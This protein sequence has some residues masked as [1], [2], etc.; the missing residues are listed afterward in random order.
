MAGAS[1]LGVNG[2]ISEREAEQGRASEPEK[3]RVRSGRG[4]ERERERE[5]VTESK[6]WSGKRGIESLSEAGQRRERCRLGDSTVNL[7]RW[8]IAMSVGSVR[9][10]NKIWVV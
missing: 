5:N 3:Q 1:W 4:R 10:Y 7:G 8:S 2:R 6:R 9:D